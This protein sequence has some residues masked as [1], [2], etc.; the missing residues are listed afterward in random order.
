MFKRQ[1]Y[2]A[3]NCIPN[4]F[5]NSCAVEGTEAIFTQSIMSY[6]E[7]VRTIVQHKS[8]LC[9]LYILVKQETY[10]LDW[11]YTGQCVGLFCICYV[12]GLLE[13]STHVQTDI[14]LHSF[15]QNGGGAKFDE[16]SPRFHLKCNTPTA[17]DNGWKTFKDKRVYYYL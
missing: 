11:T 7:L 5:Y 8:A 6:L 2:I 3:N 1:M 12:D 4:G 9:L 17:L 13:K 14:H 16:T 10:A 15:A